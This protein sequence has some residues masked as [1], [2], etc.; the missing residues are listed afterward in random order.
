MSYECART[1]SLGR[2]HARSFAL[3]LIYRP[4]IGGE[5]VE[6]I[7]AYRYYLLGWF[8]R[9]LMGIQ[10][11]AIITGD[12]IQVV[13]SA[14]GALNEF[15]NNED[16]ARLRSSIEGAGSLNDALKNIVDS[17][18]PKQGA[19]PR[20]PIFSRTEA[21][22]VRTAIDHFQSMLEKELGDLPLFC[23]EH[24]GNLDLGRLIVGA[25]DGYAT[26]AKLLIDDSIRREIDEAGRC[27]AFALPTATGF[28]ILRAVEILLK[29]YVHAV[30]GSL[31][32]LNNRNWGEYISQ[33]TNAG[34]SS[35]VTDLLKILKAKRNPLMHPQ[36]TLDIEDAIGVFCICQNVIETLTSE[37]SSKSLD[38]KLK[39]SLAVLPTI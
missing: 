3:A 33:M 34:T 10:A 37:V 28:H 29:A 21:D 6:H 30:T 5:R 14:M 39:A 32:K 12:L 26:K 7:H 2:L 23:V 4:L 16:P 17:L 15:A 31:P 38:V 22:N 8:V 24:K 35:D 36:D 13:V 27:L 19:M 18:L 1:Q 11:G 20:Q 25:S 9:G